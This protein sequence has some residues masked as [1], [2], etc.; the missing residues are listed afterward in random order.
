M[1]ENLRKH[2][3]EEMHF[4]VVLQFLEDEPRSVITQD[5]SHGGLFM[6]LKNSSYYTMGEI[7]TVSFKDPMNDHAETTKDAVIVR[8][9][10]DGI[11]IAYIDMGDF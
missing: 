9:T 1:S 2:P 10:D 4:E 11:A 5:A 8:Q 6:R 3:R 7:V